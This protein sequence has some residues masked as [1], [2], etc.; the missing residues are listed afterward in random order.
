MFYLHYFLINVSQ[1]RNLR[2]LLINFEK[3]YIEI[4]PSL[5]EASFKRVA[6]GSFEL[7]ISLLE[8]LTGQ[9]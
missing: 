7:D 9:R 3:V 1:C 4:A 8:L 5:P 6:A 2:I